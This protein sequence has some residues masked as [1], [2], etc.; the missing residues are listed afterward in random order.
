[1]TV[2]LSTVRDMLNIHRLIVLIP[3]CRAHQL[4]L[5]GYGDYD[6]QDHASHFHEEPASHRGEVQNRLCN[7]QLDY[8]PHAYPFMQIVRNRVHWIGAIHRTGKDSLWW[9]TFQPPLTVPT[10][11]GKGQSE[12][13][14]AEKLVKQRKPLPDV[15][16]DKRGKG[17]IRLH[18]LQHDVH[19]GVKTIQ[20]ADPLNEQS[21]LFQ[22]PV[23]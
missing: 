9:Y 12:L 3:F 21:L 19:F 1:M 17:L 2:A 6:E 22:S 20:P 10:P 8:W 13:S 15:S 18:E 5:A 14:P 4:R 23:P 16:R 11:P 7:C